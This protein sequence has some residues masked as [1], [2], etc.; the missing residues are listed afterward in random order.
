[1]K[2]SDGA[3]FLYKVRQRVKDSDTFKIK[4]LT[5]HKLKNLRMHWLKAV[6]ISLWKKKEKRMNS[7][8]LIIGVYF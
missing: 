2:R 1:M 4:Y 8:F 7:S 5:C 3:F 6:I